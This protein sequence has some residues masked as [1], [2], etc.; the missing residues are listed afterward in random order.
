M[1][2]DGERGEEGTDFA[3]AHLPGMASTVK[4]NVAP[5]PADIGFFSR[6]T[7]V[8]RAHPRSDCVEESHC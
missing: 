2:V 3:L 1:A 5:N 6:C 8:P 7:Q 4:C